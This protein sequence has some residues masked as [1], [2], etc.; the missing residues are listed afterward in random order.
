M[1][2]QTFVL[3]EIVVA[4]TTPG[5]QAYS[6]NRSEMR[7]TINPPIIVDGS[8]ESMKAVTNA[9]K[10]CEALYNLALG[11]STSATN[12]GTET[13]NINDVF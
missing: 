1:A 12:I 11:I 3:S 4:K 10:R 8:L 5:A 2:H 6:N 7:F 13:D 9:Y